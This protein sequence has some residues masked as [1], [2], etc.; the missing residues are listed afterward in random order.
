MSEGEDS[1][2]LARALGLAADTAEIEALRPFLHLGV[3]QKG[4]TLFDAG[5]P[6]DTASFI[7]S[8]RIAA[9]HAAGE[10]QEF[11]RGDWLGARTLLTAE[12]AEFTAR[13]LRETVVMQLPRDDLAAALAASPAFARKLMITCEWETRGESR[14]MPAPSRLVVCRIGGDGHLEPAVIDAFGSAFDA[15]A[16]V[17]VLRPESFG[18]GLPGGIS[19]AAPETQHEFQEQEQEFDLTIIPLSPPID[20]ATLRAVEEADEIL[21]IAQGSGDAAVATANPLLKHAMG[22]RGAGACRAVIVK[23]AHATRAAFASCRSVH[24]V[25]AADDTAFQPLARLM[26]GVDLS[27]AALSTG[28]QGAAV[29]G[30]L[31]AAA[32][33][34]VRIGAIGAGG[35]AV[36]A[37]ALFA[38]IAGKTVRSDRLFEGLSETFAALR[39]AAR[40]DHALYEPR[41]VDEFL[42][43]ALPDLDIAEYDTP[44]VAVSSDLSASGAA[45]LHRS[46]KLRALVRTGLTPPGLLPP[47]ITEEGRIL[48]S[49]AHHG[50]SLV[51]ALKRLTP[52]PVLQI[53]TRNAPLGPTT[54]SYRDLSG[55]A[56]FRLPGLGGHAR[57]DRRLSL[58]TLLAETACARSHLPDAIPDVMQWLIPMPEGIGPLDWGAWRVLYDIGYEWASARIQ[59]LPLT[60]L[61]RQ[62]TSRTDEAA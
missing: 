24:R 19:F 4:E 57:H 9:R 54:A 22:T 37:C 39:R 40:P 47:V 30:A 32:T 38:G 50:L 2:A 58:E 43:A 27:V 23:E 3:L 16:N 60:A 62:P 44:H 13:A 59:D 48:V 10:A 17:R 49:G 11:G 51:T 1:T 33:S 7:V 12:P 46:G 45:F 56:G 25:D 35:S 31:H 34:G 53:E 5:K 18:A 26:M 8:G 14:A 29:W 61:S 28:V 6:V 41:A 42:V 55:G 15:V 20:D 36:V 52:S 21:F